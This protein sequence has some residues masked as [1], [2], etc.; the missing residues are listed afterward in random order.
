MRWNLREGDRD[1]VNLYPPTLGYRDGVSGQDDKDHPT[2]PP[3]ATR[4]YF[5]V[6]GTKSRTL[7]KRR[8]SY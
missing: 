1:A 8:M 6:V 3:R 7:D 5:S 4:I 2:A